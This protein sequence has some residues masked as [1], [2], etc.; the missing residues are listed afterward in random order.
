MFLLCQLF[1]VMSVLFPVMLSETVIDKVSEVYTEE[2][3]ASAISCRCGL[4]NRRRSSALRIT[5]GLKEP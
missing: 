4:R 3:S 2:T 1:I 5:G